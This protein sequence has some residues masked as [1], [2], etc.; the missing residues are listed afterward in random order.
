MKS[1]L[2]IIANPAARKASR[3]KTAL[4]T[5]LL[6]KAGHRVDVLE[7]E[8][9]GHATLL[10]KEAALGGASVVIAAGGDGTFNEVMNGLAGGE[11]PMAILPTGTTNVLAKELGIPEDVN[12]AVDCI[13][14]CRPKE[15]FL[16]KLAF[17]DGVERKFFLM[18]GVGFD[19]EAV[20][21]VNRRLKKYSGKGGY[22]ASGLK[23]LAG[24]KPE[25]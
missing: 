1:K 16:A 10:A 22:F 8:A 4:A 20:Y 24:W 5:A 7:T 25:T 19:A 13:L 3:Q 15:I 21:M 12:G 14:S 6:E 18:A 11:V 23:V 17:P 9:R 2:T